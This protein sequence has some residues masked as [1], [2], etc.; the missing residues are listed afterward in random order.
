MAASLIFHKKRQ[1]EQLS[2][3][4]ELKRLF[5]ERA[6]INVHCEIVGV[7]CFKVSLALA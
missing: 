7:G 3:R 6:L 5:W 4:G 2:A 1:H